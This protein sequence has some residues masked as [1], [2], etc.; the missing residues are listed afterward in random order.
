MVVQVRHRTRAPDG[1]D[2][3]GT[4]IRPTV[5]WLGHALWREGIP[6]EKGATFYILHRGAL[7]VW[8]GSGPP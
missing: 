8:V 3:L 7:L 2:K 6:L 1:R 5:Q 4:E